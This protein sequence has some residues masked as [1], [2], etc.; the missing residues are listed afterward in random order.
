MT[1]MKGGAKRRRDAIEPEIIQAL[2]AVGWI[3]QQCGGRGLPDLLCIKGVTMMN[4]EVK[5]LAVRP[6]DVLEA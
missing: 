5:S 1:F 3:V 2:R 6:G 4:L